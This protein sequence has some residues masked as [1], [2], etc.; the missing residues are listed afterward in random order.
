D[1]FRRAQVRQILTH[2]RGLEDRNRYLSELRAVLLDT[3]VR[4]HIKRVVMQWLGAL[5]DPTEAEWQILAESR[6]ANDLPIHLAYGD[7]HGNPAWFDL[8]NLECGQ[9][10]DWLNSDDEGVRT[11]GLGLVAASAVLL[12][13]AEAVVELLKPFM[14]CEP[15]L[16]TLN[17]LFWRVKC[18]EGPLFE[19]YRGVVRESV[20]L[21]GK[22]APLDFPHDM[23]EQQPEAAVAILAEWFDAAL[24]LA[25]AEGSANPFE[26]MG[27]MRHGDYDLKGLM[28][29]GGEP[30]FREFLP[31]ICG[32]VRKNA[33]ARDEDGE[34]RDSVWRFKSLWESHHDLDD[35]LLDCVIKSGQH[36]A[37]AAPE[38]VSGLT[39]PL[40]TDPHH[41][42]AFIALRVWAANGER[43]A[44]EIASCLLGNCRHLEIG[45]SGGSIGDGNIH[46]AIAR[47]ALQAAVPHLPDET[48]VRLEEAVA[49]VNPDWENPKNT[50]AARG[51][52]QYLLLSS[53]P[54][55]RLSE[56]GRGRLG[57][58]ARKFPTT[59]TRLPKP[60]KGARWIG[61][62]IEADGIQKMSDDQWIQAMRKHCDESPD[63]TRDIRGGVHQLS[64]ALRVRA[65]EEKQR[66]AALC[67]R[68]PEELHPSYFT[69]I[70]DGITNLNAQGESQEHS[71]ELPVEN[72]DAVIKRLHGLPDQP[73]GRSIC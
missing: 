70:L 45:Y 30:F 42:I 57:E 61:P 22:E 58:L 34:L 38:V 52:S 33:L 62:P 10:A 67:L 9:I 56:A 23:F 16:S 8:L 69:S 5:A 53:I 49:E 60:T 37:E 27:N 17:R 41:T 20:L 68:M 24:E 19:F 18:M 73:C 66:F 36:L 2:L 48:I 46:L 59:D 47:E 64:Q 29:N 4:F 31:R 15:W 7:L 50:K 43:F 44:D 63:R 39:A 13:R 3:S 26:F 40:V 6:T 55:E 71:E 51:F 11:F 28:K 35:V 72:V 12:Q 32:V 14:A 21:K 1:L 54:R 65:R 25:E